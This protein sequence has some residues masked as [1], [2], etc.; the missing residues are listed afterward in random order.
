MAAHYP[1]N[2]LW[3]EKARIVKIAAPDP[4]RCTREIRGGTAGPGFF[5]HR[6][7][8]SRSRWDAVDNGALNW[9]GPRH[10]G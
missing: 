3:A 8:I 1:W 7:I 6:A 10:S 9:L 2:F 5:M 4:G